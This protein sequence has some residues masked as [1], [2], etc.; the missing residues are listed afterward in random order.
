[1]GA[2]GQALMLGAQWRAAFRPLPG[3]QELGD[4]HWIR[5]A[6][7]RLDLAV[8]DGL[9][10]GHEASLAAQAALKALDAGPGLPLPEALQACHGALR[11]TRGAAL[12]LA[13]L[14]LRQGLLSWLGVGNVEGLLLSE[15]RRSRLLCKSGIVGFNL[16]SPHLSSLPL[17]AGDTLLFCSDGIDSGFADKIDPRLGP[18]D[19]AGQLLRDCAKDSDDALALVVHLS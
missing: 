17:K 19:L 14:D 7:G 12:A 16:P 13:S 8:V 3:Q 5:A 18:L 6:P 2:D 9:G 15:G 4:A 11:G 10:H 1:M